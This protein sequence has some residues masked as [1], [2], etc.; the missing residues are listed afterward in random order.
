[1]QTPT[2]VRA[3]KRGLATCRQGIS[4]AGALLLG[5]LFM[6]AAIADAIDESFQPYAKG[7]PQ[8]PGMEKG[9]VITRRNLEQFQEYLD[10]G[11]LDA[12]KKSWVEL[13]VR[14]GASFNLEP[15]YIEATRRHAGATKLGPKDG[16]LAAYVAGRPFP[17]EPQVADPRAGEKIAWN[18]RYRQGDG[19]VIR[20]LLWKY[21]DMSSGKVERLL[22]VEV[23]GMKYKHRTSE[24]PLPDISPNPSN[25][26]FAS[27]LKIFAPNDFKNTQLLTQRY[28]DDARQ[29]DAYLYMG[30]QKRTRRL[31][32][33]QTTDAFLGS[34]VMIEDF[35][36]YNARVSEMKW[37]FKGARNLLTP[38]FN[39]DELKLSSEFNDP[40]GFQHVAF[41]GQGGC[42][43]DVHW[44]LRKNF[45]VEAE[46]LSSTH[47]VSKRV[48]YI[49]AQTNEITRT[50][51]YDRRGSLWK[52]AILAKSHPDH[53]LPANRGSGTPIADAGAM[54]DVQALHCSTA[55]FKA[56]AVPAQ[57]SQASFQ[58]QSLRG[59]D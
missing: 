3:G 23:Q 28:E 22:Q 52:M 27:Y 15:S 24:A 12:V 47:P 58:V 48:F 34:D 8:I 13:S 46:P 14:P 51:I 53:H 1:L 31:A 29:D 6:P 18:F 49:D 5:V 4:R 25:L 19:F 26:Y 39:H 44:Q 7:M 45:I 41:A 17:E 11:M 16:E 10:P 32:T 59:G 20:P 36:G 38:F 37:T 30:F 42:F 50:L 56:L 2:T 35:D 40:D 43:P 57:V 55:Q 9:G 33:G 21:V 54:I